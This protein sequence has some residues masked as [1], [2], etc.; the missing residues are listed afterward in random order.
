MITKL[1]ELFISVIIR[2]NIDVIIRVL[3]TIL[4]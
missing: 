2:V 1:I 4:Q 3:A